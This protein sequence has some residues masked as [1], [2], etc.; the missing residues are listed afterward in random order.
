MAER[1]EAGT[2]AKFK[3]FSGSIPIKSKGVQS[4]VKNR[5]FCMCALAKY[6]HASARRWKLDSCKLEVG[7][8]C[9]AFILL[10]DG[11]TWGE[12][13]EG[14]KELLLLVL[15]G[16]R[17]LEGRKEHSQPSRGKWILYTSDSLLSDPDP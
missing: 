5:E 3:K 6:H 13:R 10:E 16:G 1:Q 4:K 9:V 2:V 11:V 17:V 15:V 12:G 7:W 8:D 14:R